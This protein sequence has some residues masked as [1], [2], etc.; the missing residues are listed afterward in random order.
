MKKV[1]KTSNRVIFSKFTLP[2]STTETET[3]TET[4]KS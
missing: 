2:M 3:E 1:S 4:E